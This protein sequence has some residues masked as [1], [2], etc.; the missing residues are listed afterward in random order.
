MGNSR[1]K[2]PEYAVYIGSVTVVC[3]RA[4]LPGG[5]DMRVGLV[6][7]EVLVLAIMSLA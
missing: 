7:E 3:T 1:T 5:G 2:L 4:G 6:S